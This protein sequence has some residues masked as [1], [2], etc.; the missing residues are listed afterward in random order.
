[1]LIPPPNQ[2]DSDP[3]FSSDAVDTAE[4][5]ATRAGSF[6]RGLRSL[7]TAMS[8]LNLPRM[9]PSQSSQ[10]DTNNPAVG[11]T[12]AA[13]R[14]QYHPGTVHYRARLSVSRPRH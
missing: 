12:P 5:P 9:P 8:S 2:V 13:F 4:N 14:S 3:V 6:H 7:T 10:A 11:A 1:M